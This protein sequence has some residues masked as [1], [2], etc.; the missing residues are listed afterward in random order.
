[1]GLKLML[2]ALAALTL[3]GCGSTGCGGA[4]N[5]RAAAGLCTTHVTFLH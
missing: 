1:M 2:A 4:A 3:A 5:D